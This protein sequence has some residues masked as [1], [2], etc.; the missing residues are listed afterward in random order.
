MKNLI[1]I[2]ISDKYY[3]SSS[4][5]L[6]QVFGC[7]NPSASNPNDLRQYMFWCDNAMHE[8]VFD[9]Q[10]DYMNT[11]PLWSPIPSFEQYKSF[12][13][14]GWIPMTKDELKSH[15]PNITDY[16]WVGVPS[17]W[18]PIYMICAIHFGISWIV[19]RLFP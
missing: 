5:A 19:R 8:V 18:H 10:F 9:G 1:D 16:T 2:H 4:M 14:Q 13:S 3:I 12:I 11:R 17:R 15:F 7:R 6:T